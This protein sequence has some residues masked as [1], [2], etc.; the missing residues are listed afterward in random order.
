[1]KLVGMARPPGLH[2]HQWHRQHGILHHSH[3]RP[4]L[5]TLIKWQ[6]SSHWIMEKREQALQ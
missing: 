2:D 6:E 5:L 4:H 3:C 1:M